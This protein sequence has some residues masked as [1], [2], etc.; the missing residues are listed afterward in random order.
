MCACFGIELTTFSALAQDIDGLYDLDGLI[1]HEGRVLGGGRTKKGKG[2]SKSKGKR[3]HIGTSAS[4]NDDSEGSYS[5]SVDDGNRIGIL[6]IEDQSGFGLASSILQSNGF[7]VTEVNNQFNN[8]YAT[9]LDTQYLSRF[10]LVVYGERGDGFGTILPEAVVDSL[11]CYVQQGGH[12]LVTGYDTLGSPDDYSLAELLHLVNASDRVS[13][14][15]TWEVAYTDSFILN[16]P[17]GDFRGMM[18]NGTAYDDDLAMVHAGADTLEL[19][20]TYG[21]GYPTAKL[22]FNDFPFP[23]GSVG[24]WNGGLQGTDSNAQPDFSDRAQPQS[25]FLNWV[26]GLVSQQSRGPMCSHNSTLTTG[27]HGQSGILLIEDQSGFG[28]VVHVLESQGFEVTEVSYEFNAGYATLLDEQ[29]LSHFKLVVYGERGDGY[30]NILPQAVVDSLEC[31]VQQGGHLLV[32]GYDTLGSPDD[33]SLAELLRLINPAD[34]VSFDGTWE[35]ADIDSFILNGPYGDFRGMMFNGTA[36]DDDLAMVHAGAGT[37]ELSTT[38]G[39]GVTTAKLTFNDL[40]FPAGSVGYWNG[41]IPGV[42]LNAQPD[43]SDSAQPQMIFLNWVHGLV[44]RP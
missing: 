38:A 6:L 44:T 26:Y 5:T 23:A 12:L 11:E 39:G 31:Y 9:M 8:G 22:T 37:L 3:S 21:G 32:T 28:P 25:I 27:G 43:F 14:D 42:E 15:G 24:Y 30:G 33:Y 19:A 20:T 36:Y 18:F 2:G 29:F 41:G 16:G 17:Y 4:C 7:F 1:D 13:F 40:P 34:S 35:V 10:E